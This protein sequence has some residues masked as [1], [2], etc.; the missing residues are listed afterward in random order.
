MDDRHPQHGRN[1]AHNCARLHYV[2][3]SW[4]TAAARIYRAQIS[5]SVSDRARV[6]SRKQTTRKL[7]FCLQQLHRRRRRHQFAVFTTR[8]TA[9]NRGNSRRCFCSHQRAAIAGANATSS[10]VQLFT[11]PRPPNGRLAAAT[12]VI[13]HTNAYKHF[14]ADNLWHATIRQLF[15]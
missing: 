9:R 12:F 8:P 3:R 6:S 11:L 15:D 7:F 14:V 4:S 1:C 10:N 13:Y 5:A 2:H